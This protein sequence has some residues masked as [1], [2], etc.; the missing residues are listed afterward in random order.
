MGLSLGS[1]AMAQLPLFLARNALM[2]D[3]DFS[4]EPSLIRLVI[5]DLF[6]PSDST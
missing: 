1:Q 3:S 5:A 2:S 6:R 4:D